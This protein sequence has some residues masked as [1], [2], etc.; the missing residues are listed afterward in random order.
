MDRHEEEKA[1]L[2]IG[3][4]GWALPK[5]QAALFPS[6]GSHLERYASLFN[7]VE[8]NSSFYR[9]HQPKTYARWAASVPHNFR[10]SVKL[11]RWFT[12]ERGLA[13][14]ERLDFVLTGPR[15]L[16]EK[17]DVL[18]VQLPPKLVFDPRV[19][20]RFFR[21]LRRLYPGRVA[22]EPRHPTWAHAASLF[23]D[24]SISQ[25]LADPEVVP[26]FGARETGGFRYYRLHGSPEIY[27]S[28]YAPDFLHKVTMELKSSRLDT[29][30]I[31]DN[32]TFGHSVANARTL[33]TELSAL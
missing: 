18:L 12:H 8:I 21:A 13:E 17:W 7:S 23:R 2:R 22:C 30:C 24:F 31:F 28:E 5:S 15:E 27:R 14:T 11:A 4:A 25:V 16:G 20:E 3:T 33:L 1:R 32:T 9:E 10:F 29:W 6:P 19:A 26:D